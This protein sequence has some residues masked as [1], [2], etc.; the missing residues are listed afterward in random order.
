[1]ELQQFFKINPDKVLLKNDNL[2]AKMGMVNFTKAEMELVA[3][4]IMSKPSKLF[5]IFD[6]QKYLLKGDLPGS[7]KLPYIESKINKF[8]I[9]LD[10]LIERTKIKIHG[11]LFRCMQEQYN[12]N[13]ILTYSQWS[14]IPDDLYCS[15]DVWRPA[16]YYIYI[17]EGYCEGMY[18]NNLTDSEYHFD[19]NNF[20]VFLPRNI[21]F[22]I[23]KKEKIKVLNPKYIRYKKDSLMYTNKGEKWWYLNVIYIKII[24]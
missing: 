24:K 16:P 1:M 15:I 14:L 18:I 13:N 8:I 9:E 22:K 19:H 5:N 23:I 12:S 11:R 4:A 20:Q 3:K 6:V 17:I 2:I 7:L 10:N 21:L